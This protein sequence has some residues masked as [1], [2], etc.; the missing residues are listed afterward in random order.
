MLEIKT[1][2]DTIYFLQ[3]LACIKRYEALDI[4]R[5]LEKPDNVSE[6]YKKYKKEQPK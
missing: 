3:W 4:I 2:S 5:V 1:N 6:L